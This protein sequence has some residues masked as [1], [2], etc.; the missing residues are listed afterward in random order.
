MAG[1][2][3]SP[4]LSPHWY[5]IADL[6]PRLRGHVSIRRQVVRGQVWYV[7]S[8]PAD[9]RHY[10]LNPSAY[11]FVGLCDGQRSVA[12]IWEHMH[13]TLG[14][15]APTQ[16]D[17]VEIL[18]RLAD[19]ELLQTE[20]LPDVDVM[21]ENHSARRDKQRWSQLNPLFFRIGLLDPSAYLS[22]FDPWL[23]RLF[24]G[25]ALT[26]WL[27]IIALAGLAAAMH[28]PELA[29]HARERASSPGFLALSWLIYPLIKGL[30]ELGHALAIRR[31]GG[32]V[33]KI[34][35][36]LLVL[37]PIPWV[38][39]TASTSF[40]F[41]SHRLVVSAAGIL[42]ELFL[43]ALAFG[44][45]LLLESGTAR[46]AMLAV[47]LIAGVSTLFFNGNPLMRYDGYFILVDAIDL[48][49]LAPRSANHWTWLIKHRLLGLEAE[50]P[51]LAPGERAW[52]L[53][54]APASLLYRA[55]VSIAIVHWLIGVSASLAAVAGLILAWTFFVGPGI[56]LYR[57][58]WRGSDDSRA[59]RR[60]RRLAL[61]L[62]LGGTLALLALPLP[63]RVIAD[64]V[65]WL[66]E[67]A[68]VRPETDGLV[69]EVLATD[70]QHVAIGQP[71]L[72]LSDP[73]LI[74]E[75]DRLYAR[76]S[77]FQSEQYGILAREPE[78]ARNLAEEIESAQAA[79]RLNETRQAQLVVRA[80]SAGQL[81]L[82]R[83]ADL[84]GRFLERGTEVGYILADGGA[85]RARVLLP[86][87]DI[88]LVR[89][90]LRD[91]RVWRLETSESLS[92]R[93]ERAQPAATL[94][95]PSA[96]LGDHG[97]GEIATDA[98]DKDGLTAQEPVFVVD[99][100]MPEARPRRIG[101][102]IEARFDLGYEPIAARVWRRTRQMFLSQLGPG[103]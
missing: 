33:R 30:H 102:R 98:T 47:M 8:D 74:A 60:A 27:A 64:G 52:L 86:Q 23:K 5:R 34:G 25:V 55:I 1:D 87:E 80:G 75:H 2:M 37:M 15:A 100:L 20:V 14:E 31:W 43:A 16:A 61:S 19:G 62:I 12:E 66:P 69:V 89:E 94:R 77:R 40:R 92:A 44:A 85:M 65:V 70:G 58:I 95:L 63:F 103:G 38:D 78:R 67:N 88:A 22:V 54:Y 45:W 3:E 99:L 97:G 57:G 71:L 93:L 51:I 83:P 28:A 68:R 13:V 42:V 10:R 26:L 18:A 9:G 41:R 84:P 39:A 35:I 91:A 76:L 6:H 56:N 101:G 59:S 21:F 81:V 24:G 17:L 29:A 4:L 48:P 72:T 53:G 96:A 36:T 46:D 50:A 79:L 90:R 49:N 7:L 32:E 82:P 73:D 11:R